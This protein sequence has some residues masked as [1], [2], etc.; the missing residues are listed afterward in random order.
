MKHCV[1]FL[2]AIL[3]SFVFTGIQGFWDITRDT[4]YE[5]WG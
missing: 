2:R 1:G 4:G 5:F 3:S